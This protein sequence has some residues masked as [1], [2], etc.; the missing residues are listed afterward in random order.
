MESALWRSAGELKRVCIGTQKRLK[1]VSCMKFN[2][3]AQIEV[4]AV[5]RI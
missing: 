1:I 4:N 3:T 5:R 2:A